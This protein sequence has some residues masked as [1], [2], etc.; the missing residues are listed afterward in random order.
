VRRS[1]D[2]CAIRLVRTSAERA[3]GPHSRREP[4]GAQATEPSIRIVGHSERSGPKRS[5]LLTETREKRS[6]IGVRHPVRAR[7][8]EAAVGAPSRPDG[9]DA[10][11]TVRRSPHISATWSR[12]LVLPAADSLGAAFWD[13]LLCSGLP[14]KITDDDSGAGS[15]RLH[16][17]APG[18]PGTALRGRVEARRVPFP[19]ER[20]PYMRLLIYIP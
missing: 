13:T 14:S 20:A 9:R 4:P 1:N 8:H 19:C 2:R 12:R 5:Y 6:G 3:I 18:G 16:P 17:M 7:P 15:G 11:L 10:L